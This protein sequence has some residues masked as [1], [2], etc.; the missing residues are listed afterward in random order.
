MNNVK[1]GENMCISQSL[2]LAKFVYRSGIKYDKMINCNKFVKV[3][4]TQIS[5]L[6]ITSAVFHTQ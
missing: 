2:S 4:S 3:L 1:F 5:V 6:Y